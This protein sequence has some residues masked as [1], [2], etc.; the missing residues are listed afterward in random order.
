MPTGKRVIVNRCVKSAVSC[1]PWAESAAAAELLGGLVRLLLPDGDR[2]SPPPFAASLPP[3]VAERRASAGSRWRVRRPNRFW[4][5]ADT[6]LPYSSQLRPRIDAKNAGAIAT[7]SLDYPAKR[8][9]RKMAPRGATERG[10]E[11]RHTMQESSIPRAPFPTHICEIGSCGSSELWTC[12]TAISALLGGGCHGQNF[13]RNSAA[14]CVAAF[15]IGVVIAAARCSGRQGLGGGGKVP[16][17]L[18]TG[19][20]VKTGGRSL[21]ILG[22]R[23][24]GVPGGCRGLGLGTPSPSD[25]ARPREGVPGCGSWSGETGRAALPL[26][27]ALDTTGRRR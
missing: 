11:G 14:S 26:L 3:T 4:H 1:R 22:C 13:V 20:Q 2:P 23:R 9:G 5:D 17:G 16:P 24:E 8:V 27:E 7:P 15:A 18:R 19:V 6:R 25:N 21:T 12:A 10:P